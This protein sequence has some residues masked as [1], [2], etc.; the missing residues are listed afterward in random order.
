MYFA[1]LLY[2]H[3]CEMTMTVVSSITTARRTLVHVI[4]VTK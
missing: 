1:E 3:I 4:L 2:L